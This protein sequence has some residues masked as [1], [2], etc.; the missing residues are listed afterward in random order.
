MLFAIYLAYKPTA[1]DFEDESDPVLDADTVEEDLDD[2]FS[3]IPLI[4]WVVDEPS[5]DEALANVAKVRDRLKRYAVE[6][7]RAISLI[8]EDEEDMTELMERIKVQVEP[9]AIHT[10]DRILAEIE[11]LTR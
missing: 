1:E 8:G 5:L 11:E 7:A 4:Q 3:E 6:A 9:C 2:D 10:F